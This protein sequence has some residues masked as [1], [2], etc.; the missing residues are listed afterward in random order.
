MSEQAKP[1]LIFDW[2]KK[3]AFYRECYWRTDGEISRTPLCLDPECSEG[4]AR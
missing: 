4:P 1:N 3:C 2:C